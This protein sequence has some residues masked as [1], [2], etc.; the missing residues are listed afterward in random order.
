[1]SQYMDVQAVS[2]RTPEMDDIF[3][4]EV[5]TSNAQGVGKR[6]ESGAAGRRTPDLDEIFE[7][8]KMGGGWRAQGSEGNA[9]RRGMHRCQYSV[10]FEF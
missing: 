3:P 2:R 1:M 10:I 9:D 7:S 5:Q 6:T 4:T 8:D